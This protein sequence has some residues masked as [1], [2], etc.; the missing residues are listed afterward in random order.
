MEREDMKTN[1][2][3]KPTVQRPWGYYTVL[4][5]REGYKVKEI[6]V[7]PHSSLAMQKHQYRS[8]HWNVVEGTIKIIVGGKEAIVKKNESIFVPIDTKH[9]VY[10]E[11]DLIAKIIEVQIGSYVGE[12]DI[13]RYEKY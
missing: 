2:E 9:K 6:G 10:N 4:H 8:E 12:D 11:T 7:N 5:E 13:T 1:D 3:V